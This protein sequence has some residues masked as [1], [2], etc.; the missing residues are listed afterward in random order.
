M[1]HKNRRGRWER[2]LHHEFSMRKFDQALNKYLTATVNETADLVNS[3]QAFV[4][5]RLNPDKWQVAMKVQTSAQ[6][7]R[8]INRNLWQEAEIELAA[9]VRDEVEG[10]AR[11]KGK[12][13]ERA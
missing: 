11:M 9:I 5:E 2:Q 1:A 8:E 7:V 4:D 13:K 6:R 12:Q 3:A 10:G